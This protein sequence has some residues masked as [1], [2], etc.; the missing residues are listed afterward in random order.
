MDK[1]KSYLTLDILRYATCNNAIKH[2]S[3]A[4]ERLELTFKFLENVDAECYSLYLKA[5]IEIYEDNYPCL[6]ERFKT[7]V[8]FL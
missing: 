1:E 5:F 2:L 8:A 7:L 3:S 6:L 4:E